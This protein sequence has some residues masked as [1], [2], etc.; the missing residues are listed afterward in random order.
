MASSGTQCYSQWRLWFIVLHGSRWRQNCSLVS[1]EDCSEPWPNRLSETSLDTPQCHLLCPPHARSARPQSFDTCRVRSCYNIQTRSNH[2][3]CN[4]P[5]TVNHDFPH[6]AA[7]KLGGASHFWT[8]HLLSKYEETKWQ[9]SCTCS[10]FPARNRCQYQ[11]SPGSHSADV[12]D[13][14]WGSNSSWVKAHNENHIIP[15]LKS[16]QVESMQSDQS[17]IQPTSENIPVLS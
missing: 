11:S 1:A 13:V 2:F 10:Q 12:A 8:T 5:K 15:R 17:A 6:E 3:P 7:N 4:L 9:R 14:S 16:L